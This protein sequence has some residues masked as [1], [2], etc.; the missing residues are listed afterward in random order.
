VVGERVGVWEGNG[1]DLRIGLPWQAVHD[2]TRW[3]HTPLRLT[4]VVEAPVEAVRSVI[5]RH[6]RLGLLVRNGWLH[7][8]VIPPGE[9]EPRALQP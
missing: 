8:W 6:P 7:L 3:M 1:G 4:T 5:A 9:E 2:G